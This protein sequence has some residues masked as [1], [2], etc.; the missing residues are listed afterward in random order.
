[1]PGTNHAESG[2]SNDPLPPPPPVAGPAQQYALGQQDIMESILCNLGDSGYEDACRAAARWCALNKRHRAMCQ[3]S[4]DAPWTELTARVFGPNAPV[5]DATGGSQK[6]F[7]ALYTRAGAY[8]WAERRLQNNPEDANVPVFVIAEGQAVDNLTNA[9]RSNLT[10]VQEVLS[11]FDVVDPQERKDKVLQFDKMCKLSDWFDSD[12]SDDFCRVME[13]IVELFERLANIRR[14]RGEELKRVRTLAITLFE[15]CLVFK[16]LH[17]EFMN[18]LG[19]QEYHKPDLLNLLTLEEGVFDPA[20]VRALVA[21]HHTGDHRPTVNK[22]NIEDFYHEFVKR[23]ID[24]WY[25]GVVLNFDDHTTILEGYARSD[26]IGSL[27]MWVDTIARRM[28]EYEYG[29][30]SEWMGEYGPGY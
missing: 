13:E 21:V 25:P 9:L 19:D 5:L 3:A 2:G 17:T 23:N 16:R 26:A 8:S 15:Q 24:S 11:Q 6:N 22:Q 18:N 20:L 30:W 12:A 14:T 28:S 7:Y 27:T 29:D 4:G 1:M 10:K